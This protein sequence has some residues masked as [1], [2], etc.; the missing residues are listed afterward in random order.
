MIRFVDDARGR[1]GVEPICRVLGATEAGFLTASGYRAA[2]ARP[3]SARACRDA[4]LKDVIARV[5]AANYGVY[6]VRKM[7]AALR[8]AGVNVGRDQTARLMRELGLAG[9][10]RGRGRRTTVADETAPRPADLMQR[11]FTASRPNQLWVTDI[12]YV[13]TW[14]GWAYLAL[15]IDVYSGWSSAGR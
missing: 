13:R 1:F 3:P 9:A 6:G 10:R 5:H 4:E 11:Q 2:K 7:H 14:V 8:R 12:T 15:V